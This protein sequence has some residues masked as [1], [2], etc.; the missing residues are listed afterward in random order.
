MLGVRGE[1]DWP[2]T[3]GTHSQSRGGDNEE[4]GDQRRGGGYQDSATVRL[5]KVDKR[6]EDT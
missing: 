6:A 5:G 2:Y 4:T 1:P 3:R